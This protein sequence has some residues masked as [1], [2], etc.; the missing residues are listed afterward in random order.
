MDNY[1]WIAPAITAVVAIILMHLTFSRS[2]KDAGKWE[3]SVNAKIESFEKFAKDIREELKEIRDDVKKIFERLPAKATASL[4]PVRLTDLGKKVSKEIKASN[5]VE[6]VIHLAI[7]QVKGKDH[8]DIQEFC[9]EYVE[10]ESVLTE[11]MNE[12]VKFSAYDNGI[13]KRQV[14]R[15][16]AIELRDALFE[17]LKMDKDV[18]Y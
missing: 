5:W 13:E 6:K 1:T 3:G 4:S 17:Q 16:L 9:F 12:R 8:Y 2:S 7:P 15:V 14:L 11:K 10:Q 18:D